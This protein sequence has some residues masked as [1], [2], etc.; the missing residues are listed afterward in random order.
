MNSSSQMPPSDLNKVARS[1]LPFQFLAA[2]KP[3]R[4]TSIGADRDSLAARRSCFAEVIL[5]Q[6]VQSDL[7]RLLTSKGHSQSPALRKTLERLYRQGSWLL[8]RGCCQ[9]TSST[10]PTCFEGSWSVWVIARFESSASQGPSCDGAVSSE[11]SERELMFTLQLR[12]HRQK[13]AHVGA[14][15][16]VTWRMGPALHA[17]ECLEFQDGEELTMHVRLASSGG[18]VG[19]ASEPQ[20]LESRRYTTPAVGHQVQVADPRL[21]TR[22]PRGQRGSRECNERGLLMTLLL[23]AGLLRIDSALRRGRASHPFDELEHLIKRLKGQGLPAGVS[24]RDTYLI[25][26]TDPMSACREKLKEWRSEEADCVPEV[27]CIFLV[28]SLI[29][30]DCDGFLATVIS[31]DGT[32]FPVA[33]PPEVR[34]WANDA[35]PMRKPFIGLMTVRALE[36][37]RELISGYIHPIQSERNFCPVESG[38]ERRMVKVLKDWHDELPPHIQPK[39]SI[40]KVEFSTTVAAAHLFFDAEIVIALDEKRMFRLYIESLGSDD[41]EYLETKRILA[42]LSCQALR[43]VLFHGLPKFRKALGCAA[44]G[45]SEQLD[46]LT[47]L[48]QEMRNGDSRVA[49]NQLLHHCAQHRAPAHPEPNVRCAL[50]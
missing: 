23:E 7:G 41:P 15:R 14:N 5:E 2:R 45:L 12:R 37:G 18:V 30:Q 28:R 33:L 42:R 46:D 40:L 13:H 43:P 50:R 21:K 32:A 16:S 8:V 38:E 36:G 49:W 26:P 48:I 47:D 6:E 22:S 39:V 24:V 9:A 31:R 10:S 1:P 3:G 44:G 25:G 20:S 4:N 34:L 27:T 19:K 35:S 17:Q 11:T 29:K